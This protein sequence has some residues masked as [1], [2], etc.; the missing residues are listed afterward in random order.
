MK[1]FSFGVVVLVLATAGLAGASSVGPK[2]DIAAV[3]AT[4]AKL[5]SGDTATEVHVVGN[6]ALVNWLARPEGSGFASY[7]RVSGEKWKE[8]QFSG[9]AAGGPSGLTG[10]PAAIAKQLCGGKGSWSSSPC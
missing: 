5:H 7:K 10:I 3:S 6:Y 4:V 8:L 9:G 1:K 2:A